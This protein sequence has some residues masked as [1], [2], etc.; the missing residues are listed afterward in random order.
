V[1]GVANTVNG[2][3]SSSWTTTTS[4]D[5]QHQQGTL[6]TRDFTFAQS[7]GARCRRWLIDL[8]AW[9]MKM[10]VDLWRRCQPGLHEL[11]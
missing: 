9:A 8:A 4:P 10:L 5:V 2:V 7:A 3:L 1:Q 11:N 6:V